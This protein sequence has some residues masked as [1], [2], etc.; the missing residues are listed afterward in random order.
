CALQVPFRTLRDLL[1]LRVKGL[2]LRSRRRPLRCLVLRVTPIGRTPLNGNDLRRTRRPVPPKRLAQNG[3]AA[4][5]SAPLPHRRGHA[6]REPNRA[7]EGAVAPLPQ[8]GGHGVRRV[9][10][11]GHESALRGDRPRRRGPATS[12]GG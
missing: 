8:R 9:A 11:Q 3:R 6:V 5:R 1:G 4:G 2:I 12:P 7:L 10:D